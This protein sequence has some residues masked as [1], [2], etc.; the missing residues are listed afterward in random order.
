MKTKRA[1]SHQFSIFYKP[2][3]SKTKTKVENI[4]IKEDNN[5]ITDCKEVCQIFN[6]FFR[7]IGSE[8][9]NIEDNN[10]SIDDILLDYANHASVKMISTKIN[11]L[12]LNLKM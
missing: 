2:V 7:V 8:I 1:L 5:I 3:F 10:K 11:H 12:H 6:R 9:G 4:P